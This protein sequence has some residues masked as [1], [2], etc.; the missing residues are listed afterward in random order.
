MSML[1]GYLFDGISLLA[2]IAG[3]VQFAD[4]LKRRLQKKNKSKKD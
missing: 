4:I 3:I 2:S 1:F